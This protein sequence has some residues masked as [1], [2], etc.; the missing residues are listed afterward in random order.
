MGRQGTEAGEDGQSLNIRFSRTIPKA[1][2]VSTVTVSKDTANRYFVSML[3]TDQVTAK[4]KA[5][6]KVGIDL[7][8]THFAILSTGEKVASAAA[9]YRAILKTGNP[10]G[11]VYRYFR[12][13][14]ATKGFDDKS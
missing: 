6:G 11:S 9:R 12:F 10:G 13:R 4:N 1:V 5:I 2:V 7:G 8:L 3:C 14:Y